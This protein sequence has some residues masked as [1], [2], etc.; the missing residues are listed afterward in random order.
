MIELIVIAAFLS[1]AVHILKLGRFVIRMAMRVSPPGP[2]PGIQQAG[3]RPRNNKTDAPT[4][5]AREASVALPPRESVIDVAPSREPEQHNVSSR[6]QSTALALAAAVF[7]TAG[8]A[9]AGEADESYAKALP[10]VVYIKAFGPN[11]QESRGTG[12]LVGD[13]GLII[14]A[15]HVVTG[16]LVAAFPPDYDDRGEL[17]TE[18]SHYEEFCEAEMCITLATDVKRD[19]SLLR[20]RTGRE[21]LRGMKFSTKAATP[22][23]AVYTIGNNGTSS[24]WNFAS[25]NVRQVYHHTYTPRG[26]PTVSARIIEMS[27]PIYPGFSGGP[28]FSGSGELLGINAATVTDS[29]Q[30]HYGIDRIEVVAFLEEFFARVKAK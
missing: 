23:Q 10:S 21:G 12:V 29:N 15:A 25:G 9:Q 11:W 22:G 14:T 5:P 6:P 24:M 30:V 7:L 17:I 13:Q 28:I 18:A 1:L 4:P 26:S 8:T 2:P 3:R 27:A 16:K 20:F 19:L